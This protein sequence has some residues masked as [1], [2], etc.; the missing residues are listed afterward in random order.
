MTGD[1]HT[2][3]WVPDA[4]TLPTADRPLRQAEFDDLFTSQIDT[5]ERIGPTHLRLTMSGAT[6]L[7]TAVRDLTARE[8]QC[9]SFFTFTVAAVSPDNLRLDIEVPEAHVDVLD[10]LANRAGGARNPR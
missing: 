3:G 7:E 8:T 5:A 6:G 10:A 2:N 1:D 9:C 4:C